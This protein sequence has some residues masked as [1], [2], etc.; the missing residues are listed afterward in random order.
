MEVEPLAMTRREA[1]EANVR[2]DAREVQPRRFEIVLRCARATRAPRTKSRDADFARLAT[3]AFLG[4]RFVTRVADASPPFTP[5]L[6]RGVR[7]RI[8]LN[9]LQNSPSTRRKPLAMRNPNVPAN[10]GGAFKSAFKTPKLP[11]SDAV[12]S[13]PGGTTRRVSFKSSMATGAVTFGD[14]MDIGTPTAKKERS[15][16]P[17]VTHRRG[18]MR[19]RPGT[20]RRVAA[21][22]F[23]LV[24]KTVPTSMRKEGEIYAD[25]APPPSAVTLRGSLDG[26]ASGVAAGSGGSGASFDGAFGL[27]GGNAN[28]TQSGSVEQGGAFAEARRR[29]VSFGTEPEPPLNDVGPPGG[30]GGDEMDDGDFGGDGGGYDGDDWGER[31]PAAFNYHHHASGTLV[32]GY[33]DP[34]TVDGKGFFGRKRKFIG[35]RKPAGTPHKRERKEFSRRKSLV[36]AGSRHDLEHIDGRPIRRSTRQRCKP[37]EYWRG[38]TKHY[39]RTHASLPTVEEVTTRTPNPYWPMKTP[40][41]NHRAGGGKRGRMD[42]AKAAEEARLRALQLANIAHLTD[43]EDD[44]GDDDDDVHANDRSLV[45]IDESMER[46]AEEEEADGG[47]GRRSSRRGGGGGDGGGDRRGRG[48]GAGRGGDGHR[49]GR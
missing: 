5:R 43:S 36:A 2:E 38:E 22:T 18:M 40:A 29:G 35:P 1:V 19:T 7:A 9:I 34:M 10:G 6:T 37:L 46:E 45:V 23:S 26:S 41:E 14:A 25:P 3:R 42:S 48:G 24:L 44:D 39:T 31:T 15:K 28:A 12:A 27:T 33:N 17:R 21:R 8:A 30:F 11:T 16:P 20:G 49:P 13:S 4:K 32:D 47:G